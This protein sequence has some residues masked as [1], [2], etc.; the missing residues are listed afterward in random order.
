[1]LGLKQ[2]LHQADLENFV[3][4]FSAVFIYSSVSTKLHLMQRCLV[5]AFDE[6]IFATTT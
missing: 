6:C 5:Q 3:I 2:H 4:E 1:M